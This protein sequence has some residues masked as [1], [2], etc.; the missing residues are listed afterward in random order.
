AYFVSAG[1]PGLALASPGDGSA[2]VLVTGELRTGL[3]ITLRA[4][5][6]L[7]GVVLDGLGGPIAGAHV[8]GLRP[9]VHRLSL[10]TNSDRDGH[11]ELWA[12]PGPVLLRADADGYAPGVLSSVLPAQRVELVLMPAGSIRGRVIAARGGAGVAGV[13]VRAEPWPGAMVR[14]LPQSVTSDLDG[15]FVLQGVETAAYTVIA[16]GPGLRG[17]TPE[18]IEVGLGQSVE[19]VIVEVARALQVSGQVLQT[20]G[21]PCTQGM[22]MLGPSFASRRP[23]DADDDDATPPPA[24]LHAAIAVDGSV[25]FEA[26]PPGR[27]HVEVQ[28]QDRVVHDGPRVIELTDRDANGLRWQVEPGLG[29]SVSVVDGA[30]K[31]VAGA[32]FVLG[33]PHAVGAPLAVMP[34]TADTRGRYDT[35]LAL[36]P[37]DYTLSADGAQQADEVHVSL[38]AGAGRVPATLVLPGTAMIAVDVQDETG[39]GIEGATVQASAVGAST[40]AMPPLVAVALGEGHYRVGPL[41]AGRYEVSADDGV[42]PPARITVGSASAQARL[43]IERGAALHG[44]VLDDRGKGVPD[45]WVSAQAEEPAERPS[46]ARRVLSDDT[47]SFAIEA[48]SSSAALVVRAEQPYGSSAVLHGVRS[49]QTVTLSLP[50]L[51]ELRG[52]VSD[53]SGQPVPRFSVQVQHVAT[54]QLRALDVNDVSGRFR[55]GGVIT[56]SLEVVASDAA[57]RMARASVQLESGAAAPLAL[58]LAAP[59]STLPPSAAG[60]VATN[61]GE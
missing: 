32:S 59:P 45:V 15:R 33:F 38:R 13:S 3:D 17:Q 41:P 51:G 10:D 24:S 14:S 26:V 44:R 37:G 60:V 1:A 6:R 55:I 43:V 12:E 58:V 16:E 28:C 5:V 22:V 30:G 31:P 49:G 47:G 48:L 9:E 35:P 61:E 36:Y 40:I 56:G 19:D 29:L 25:T 8:R 11:F 53:A 21:E 52:V 18:A 34:L 20:S 7:S 54:G 23:A 42:N 27:Y 39:T 46:P 2:I 50:A 57:G 4:G